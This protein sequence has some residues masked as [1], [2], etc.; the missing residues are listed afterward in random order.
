MK[1]HAVLAIMSLLLLLGCQQGSV[2]SPAVLPDKAM[3]SKG[4]EAPTPGKPQLPEQR[5]GAS[6]KQPFRF[7]VMGDSRGGIGDAIN[8]ATLRRLLQQLKTLQ[9]QPSFILFTGDQIKGSN[10]DTELAEWKDI[11]DDYYPIHL[12]YP[13]LG[14]H[15]DDEELFSKHFAHL[16]NEQLAGYRKS[17]YSFDYQDARF[18]VLNS[19]RTNEKKQY[20]VDDRQL[21]YL[22]ERLQSSDKSYDFVIFHVP[23]YPASAHFGK[24]LDA[25]PDQRDALWGL[26]DRYQV[27][28][29]MVGH[30]HN[31]NRRTVDS[32]F[33]EQ[34]KHAINQLTVG[35]AGAPLYST[36]KDKKNVIAGPNPVYHYM[37]VD[38]GAGKAEFQ[39]YDADNKSI[40][41]FSVAAR[42]K[43]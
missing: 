11:V 6:N 9:P 25:D 41:R 1:R 26:L 38:I 19:N 14:N 36:V 23:A 34:F 28:A 29:A 33:N 40:D 16:P 42:A 43:E 37:V 7:I 2:L 15:D 8:E 4:N 18:V 31:Y 10:V 20:I 3:P 39:V 5:P 22:E 12:Y 13:T 35:G 27:T 32:S 21:A 17:V 30:E 24:S